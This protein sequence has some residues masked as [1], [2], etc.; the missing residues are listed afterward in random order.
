MTSTKSRVA[1]A[2]TL[3]VVA[4]GGLLAVD[5]AQRP[6]PTDEP[7]NACSV[8]DIGGTLAGDHASYDEGDGEGWT[9][10]QLDDARA[11][12][13]AECPGGYVI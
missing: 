1:I 8:D 5:I 10:E 11:A 2:A 9:R 13:L 3:G 4:L 6:A 7:V 12:L